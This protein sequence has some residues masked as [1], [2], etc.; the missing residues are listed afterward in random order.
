VLTL[1]QRVRL[2][3]LTAG[4][5]ERMSAFLDTERLGVAR[6]IYNDRMYSQRRHEARELGLSVNDA[7]QEPVDLD[8]GELLGPAR[9]VWGS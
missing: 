6:D 7:G 9:S 5:F 8:L 3:E 1:T 4:Q 2:G